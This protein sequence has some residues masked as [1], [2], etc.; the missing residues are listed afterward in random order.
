MPNGRPDPSHGDEVA[1]EYERFFAPIGP[2]LNEIARQH[3]LFIEKYYHDAPCWKL[4]FSHPQGGCA[5]IDVCRQSDETVIIVGA[6]WVDDY[7]G[8]TRSLKS[9]DKE[10]VG[11]DSDSIKGGVI[12]ALQNV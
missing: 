5:G 1:A 6:W 3:N 2:A 7:D 10:I 11:R 4:C 8:G 9:T 12:A